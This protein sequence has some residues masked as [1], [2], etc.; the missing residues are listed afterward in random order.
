MAHHGRSSRDY[1]AGRR[2][3]QHRSSRDREY[4]SEKTPRTVPPHS[5]NRRS[6]SRRRESLP[7]YNHNGHAVTPGI[8]PEG[9]SG[10]RGFNPIKF[11]VICGRSSS[12]PSMLVNM[13]WP[14]V[15]VAIA[16]HFAKP[17][18]HL[19][20]FI[21]NYIAM[22]PAANMLG[23]AGQEFSRK[24]PNKAFAVVLETTFGSIVEIILF[25][26]LLKT[27]NGDSNVQ[28]IRAAILGSIL[29]NLLLCLGVCFIAGGLKNKT[30][31]FHSAISENGSG[32]MLVASMALVLPAIFYS[33]LNGNVDFEQ[34]INVATNTRLISRGVAIISIVGFF[35]YL[36]F[37][38]MSHDGLLHEIYEADDHKDKDR[39]EELKKP[40][41]TMTEVIIALIISVA[42]VALVAI[43][44]VQEIPHLVEERGISDAFIGLILIPLVEKIAEHLL[45]ID[46]AYDNQINMA[47]AHVLGASI[48][49]ALFNA[50]LVVLVGWGIGVH[51]DYNFT[52]FDAAAL[53]LAV[54]AVGSFL[55]DGSSNY[56][57][58]VLCVMIYM[59][60]AICAFY[61]PNPLHEG[62]AS[63]GHSTGAAEGGGGH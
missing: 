41:L 37:Q 35:I 25:M 43:A 30:Q 42:C 40:K 7:Q 53:V 19:P 52:M 27:S 2:S 1:P 34:N 20:I 36:A 44:L 62:A 33:Y 11:L 4:T 28:V 6:R 48:Q 54:L 38:T 3:S 59:I 14:I 8:H 26:T 46:E 63:G 29:A 10:R 47:L 32:L 17:E 16:M 9:E 50:P 5:D 12:M 31:E 39:H 55:R 45:A 13:L 22:L 60:I 49:T 24:M 23:F 56:L 61:F 57:E 18:W 58:G 51:M 21:C 15:P